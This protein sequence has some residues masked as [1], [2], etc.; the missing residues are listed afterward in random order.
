MRFV[1]RRAA[2]GRPA[3]LLL[4]FLFA[5]ASADAGAQPVPTWEVGAGVQR[6]SWEEAEG[7]G[8]YGV[9]LT[10]ARR[11][12][13]RFALEAAAGYAWAVTRDA[14]RTGPSDAFAW[15]DRSLA[16]ADLLLAVEPVR[17]AH[18]GVT[19][20]LRL[21][22]GPSIHVRW[23]ETPR[24]FYPDLDSPAEEADLLRSLANPG[25]RP[26]DHVYRFG[27]QVPTDDEPVSYVL[28]NDDAGSGLGLAV[29][30]AYGLTL[31]RT[32]LRLAGTLRSFPSSYG[33]IYGVGVHVGRAW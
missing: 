9:H 23:G 4:A 32:T 20:S 28:T 6:G 22:A 31:G 11:L 5:L 2:Q 19:H 15:V 33:V 10:G 3:F 14:P 12:A 26:A 27:P 7:A 25:L 1:T 16:V 17:Q 29:G 8:G 13:G 24:A 30:L 21:A 18:A